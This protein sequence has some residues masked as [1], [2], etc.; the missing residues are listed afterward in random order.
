MVLLS[1]IST[2][3]HL[4]SKSTCTYS[5]EKKPGVMSCIFFYQ[6][7]LIL[8]VTVDQTFRLRVD[9][10]NKETHLLFSNFL[11]MRRIRLDLRG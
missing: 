6:L 8:D 1:N 5:K 7:R 2:I 3:F 10:F 9:E 11:N 4:T